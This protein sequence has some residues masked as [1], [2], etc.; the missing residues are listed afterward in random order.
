MNSHIKKSYEFMREI[1]TAALS[2]L[3][4]L[5]DP[6]SRPCPLL[7]PTGHRGWAKAH[8]VR[9]AALGGKILSLRTQEYVAAGWAC[10]AGLN[11]IAWYYSLLHAVLG[12][13]CA[14]APDGIAWYVFCYTLHCVVPGGLLPAGPLRAWPCSLPGLTLC[15]VAMAA[16]LLLREICTAALSFLPPLEDPW[17]G[18]GAESL[19]SFVRPCWSQGVGESPQRARCGTR[20]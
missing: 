18:A 6:W 20:G 8:D 1:C 15:P 11:E 3:P 19:L 9:A 12:W 14:A 2:F 7:Y 5:V 16:A 13:A 10:A 4:P 17:S